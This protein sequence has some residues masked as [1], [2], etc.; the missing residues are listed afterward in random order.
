[1]LMR[2]FRTR[3][4]V[5]PDLR[6]IGSRVV[7]IKTL[8]VLVRRFRIST[9]TVHR[10][11]IHIYPRYNWRLVLLDCAANRRIGVVRCDSVLVRQ[12]TSTHG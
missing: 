11:L 2:I 4:A 3:T 9:E 5:E 1:M 10:L 12:V 7:E 8:G 6:H